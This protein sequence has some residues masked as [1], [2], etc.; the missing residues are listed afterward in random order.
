MPLQ[1][2]KA[3]YRRF[4]IIYQFIFYEIRI[5]LNLSERCNINPHV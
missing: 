3:A 5:S 1:N 2:K 4:F